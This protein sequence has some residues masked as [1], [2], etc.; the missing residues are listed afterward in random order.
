MH[1]CVLACVQHIPMV[2]H[3]CINV[4]PDFILCQVFFTISYHS[5]LAEVMHECS[6]S[7]SS[8]IRDKSSGQYKQ[9]VQIVPHGIELQR[10]EH[11]TAAALHQTCEK[12]EMR[13]IFII[14]SCGLRCSC[15]GNEGYIVHTVTPGRGPLCSQ[16]CPLSYRAKPVK[17]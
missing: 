8:F 3:V 9:I 4:A 2:A 1:N 11:K 7:R 15:T 6:T 13:T 14:Y 17:R 12:R 5:T 10:A 16:F